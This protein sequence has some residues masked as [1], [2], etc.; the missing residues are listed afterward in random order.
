MES[1]RS[2]GASGLVSRTESVVESESLA[3]GYD[4]EVEGIDSAD[5]HD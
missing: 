2:M 5:E 3:T 1:A 4:V